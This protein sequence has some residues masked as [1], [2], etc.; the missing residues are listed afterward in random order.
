MSVTP[1]R[2]TIQ[3]HE[4]AVFTWQFTPHEEKQYHSTAVITMVYVSPPA[5]GDATSKGRAAVRLCG[6]GTIGELK[7]ECVTLLGYHF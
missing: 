5:S 2:G 4:H 7:V 6:Q 3:P 1:S